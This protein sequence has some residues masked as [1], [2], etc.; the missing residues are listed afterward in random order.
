[1]KGTNRQK[2]TKAACGLLA[3]AC[4]LLSLSLPVRAAPADEIKALLEQ[5]RAADAY[6]LGRKHPE[7]FGTSSFDFYYGIAATDSGH[8]G[9]GVLAL[10]R[11]LLNFPD[12]DVARVELARSYFALGDVVRARE[13]FE[14][15]LRNDPPAGVRA[16][17]DRYI[18]SIRLRESRFQTTSAVWL[19]A[20]LGTDS[21]VNGGVGSANISVPVFGPVTVAATGVQRGDNFWHVAGGAYISHP[22]APG[23]AVFG[24]VQ[25]ETKLNFNAD[26]FDQL[27]F[28]AAGGLSYLRDQNTYRATLTTQSLQ[29]DNQRY[30]NATGVT[31]EWLHALDELRLLTLSGQVIDLSYTGSNQVRDA[32]FYGGAAAYRHAFVRQYQ[33]V[34]DVALSLG[35]EDNQRDRPDLGR[36]IL[37]LRAAVAMTPAAKWGLAAGITYQ[38]SRYGETDALFLTT[39]KDN[40]Y[41]IDLTATYLFSRQ[42]SVRAEAIIARNDSNIALFEYDRRVFAV[43]ARY[44]F[45]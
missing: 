8:A 14:A 28:G 38:G 30:R 34:V 35:R 21:N 4:L 16:T 32:M 44:E 23:V 11:Y 43:K 6:A 13:E 17:V 15:V 24:S 39:R 41:G 1:V 7:L 2:L 10:E 9:E 31:G 12:S 22:V 20:G 19:E 37:G 40:Y 33:P 45:K 5:G 18:E 25:G 26:Q 3:F 36:D 29:V 42:F 27:T